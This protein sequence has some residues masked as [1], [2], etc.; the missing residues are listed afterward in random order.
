MSDQPPAQLVDMLEQLGLATAAQVARMGRRTRRLARDLPRFESVWINELAQARILTPFQ[1]AEL[2]AGRGP[3]LRIGPY[4]LC[5]RLLHPYY[6]PSYRA[7]NVDSGQIVQLA[8]IQ[9]AR[10]QSDEVLRQLESLVGCV[11]RR[12]RETRLALLALRPSRADRSCC[13]RRRSDFRRRPVDRRAHGRRVHDS[14][15]KIPFAS[16]VAN[17]SG[18]AGR[19]G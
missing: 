15:R 3:A 7:R 11:K 10:P 5:Q 1:A 4:V 18:H 17:R 12:H 13:H 6:V 9:L 8:A 2:N 19:L 16:R 14:P